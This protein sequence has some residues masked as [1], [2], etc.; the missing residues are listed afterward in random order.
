M[1]GFPLCPAC[2]A[3]YENPLD[4]RFHA[5]PVACPRCGPSLCY[6]GDGV[7]VDGNEA[8]LA[9]AI[10]TLRSGKIVAV[11]GI[12]GYHLLCDA[13]N[14]AAVSRL[15]ER[16]RRPHKPLA[17]LFPWCG[18]DGL[19]AVRRETRPG[20]LEQQ[21]LCSPERPIVLCARRPDTTLASGIAPGLTEI[22][23]M[24]PYS[25]LHHLLLDDF[26]GPLVATSGN[27]SGEPVLTDNRETE[28]RLAGIADAFL[29]HDRPIL[30]PAD[31]SVL[32]VSAGRARPLRLG[33]GI[34]PL[35]LE[36]PFALERPTLALG[37]QMKNAIALAWEDRLVLSPH[38]GELG[39][40][41]AMQVFEQL[42][43]DLQSLYG[44][45]AEQLFCDAHPGYAS[46]RWARH[47]GLPVQTVFHHH[48]HA[49]A[50]Y[51]EHRGSGDW[52]VFTWDGTGYGEDGN[53]WGGEALLGRPGH[54][55]RMARLR[56]FRLPGGE[57]AGREP[58]R[59]A[60]A[61]C[62]ETNITWA[63]GPGE[64]DL[65]HQAWQRRLNTPHTTSAGRLFDAAA[66][67]LGLC[68]HTS[69]EG[70]GP[71]QLEAIATTDAKAIE[72][73]IVR[74]A[75]GVL[76]IDWQ[77]LLPLLLDRSLSAAERAGIFHASLAK[78]IVETIERLHQREPVEAI[79]LSG[80]VFQNRRLTEAVLAIASRKALP[81][82]VHETI[83][84]ND[85]GIAYGQV[86][87]AAHWLEEHGDTHQ[88]FG[89]WWK[90]P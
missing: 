76:Q 22:G 7:Q 50:L 61:L 44:V 55:Q 64:S 40:P 3:E 9:A 29:R 75:D 77:P 89:C 17:V 10:A 24:L 69:F 63:G 8:V 53:L 20:P 43:A 27:L 21:A 18:A 19:L 66:A 87:E 88:N 4:R 47:S 23:V 13:R 28:Q 6:H 37:A 82:R 78:A 83:P 11:K 70:Q 68:T 35:E 79:G 5:E 65:L 38:I 15:R 34:A 71:M 59:S 86:I 51:G 56:P 31:D 1:A 58:W 14:E 2:Q 33:R 49:A 42:A 54:W 16:K 72:L 85:G 84:C 30:R 26:D 80:G 74:T 25:P 41:R 48:A 73:P 52:L 36:L 45:R 62:W 67:L 81:I 12:G 60:L 90:P 46:Q 32:R 57:K 39:S